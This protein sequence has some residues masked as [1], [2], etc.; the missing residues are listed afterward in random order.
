MLGNRLR[1]CGTCTTPWRRIADGDEPPIS[2]P[3]RVIEP[4]R[5]RSRPLTV[6]STVDL[7]APLG[8]TTQVIISGSS[9]RSTPRRISAAP[10]PAQTPDSVST[11]SRP[12]VGVEDG[13]VA[14]HGG[15]SSLGD[16]RAVVEHDHRVAESHYHMHVVLDEQEGQP[17]RVQL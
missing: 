2:T 9:A 4:A 1:S 3:S 13:G 7:P 5:G 6:R 8:P 15:G 12:Q 17:L 10:Y 11:G 16:L 14:L